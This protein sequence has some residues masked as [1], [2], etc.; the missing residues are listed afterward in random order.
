MS[1]SP[2]AGEA[3]ALAHADFTERDRVTGEDHFAHAPGRTCQACGR[4][5]GPGRR[6]AAGEKRTGCTMSAPNPADRE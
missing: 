3:T 1:V 4:T 2:L 5:I 6:P